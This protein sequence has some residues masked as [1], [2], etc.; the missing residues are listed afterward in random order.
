MI[1]AIIGIIIG[2]PIMA[3]LAIAI[4]VESGRPVI[5]KQ[6]RIGTNMEPFTF[7]KFRSLK[8]LSETELEKLNNPNATIK[9]RVTKAGKLMRKFRIDELPQF[10]NVLNGT[11][12]VI[13]PRPEM[14]AYHNQ[15]LENIPYYSLRYKM[16]PGITGW[17]QINYKHT[18]GL[19]DYKIKTEYDL[20]YIKNRSILLDL[21]ITLRTIETM[22]GMRGAR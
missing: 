19:E 18:S 4:L 14:P 9:Q 10:F 3:I 20:Y 21:Q 15:C 16:K 8:N 5:F 22:L 13:G 1:F 11:M 12:S 2:S 17:A 6:K 7:I